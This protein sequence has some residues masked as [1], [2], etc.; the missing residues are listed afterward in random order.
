MSYPYL[1]DK[2]MC[3]DEIAHNKSEAWEDMIDV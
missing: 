2:L 3:I 1:S